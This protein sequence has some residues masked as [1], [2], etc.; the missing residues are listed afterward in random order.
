MYISVHN[1]KYNFLCIENTNVLER[2]RNG[3]NS[4]KLDD[5]QSCEEAKSNTNSDI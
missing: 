2:L 1:L 5:I 4:V 3:D